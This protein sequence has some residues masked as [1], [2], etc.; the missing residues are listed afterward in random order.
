MFY[1]LQR[2]LLTLFL[3]LLLV[4]GFPEAPASYPWPQ[5]GSQLEHYLLVAQE[6]EKAKDYARSAEAYLN[7]LKIRPDWALIH[8]S[9]G[10]VYHLQSR[11]PEAI[12]V[13]EKALSLDPRLWGSR[14]FLGMDYYR[15]NQFSKAVP[16]LKKA[17]ELNPPLAEAEAR[18]W[19]GSSYLAMDRFEEAIEQWRRLIELRPGDLEVLYNLAQAYNRF[20]SSLFEAMGK[21]DLHSA[22]A[23]RLQAEWFESQ[24]RPGIA[25]EEYT[26]AAE[27]RPDWEGI[28]NAIGSIYARQGEIEKA[29]EAFENELKIVP[30]DEVVQKQLVALKE[31][32]NESH[33]VKKS[34]PGTTTLSQ[35]STPAFFSGAGSSRKTEMP[36]S[37]LGIEEFRARKFKEAIE[38][39]QRALDS[40]PNDRKA[41]LYLAR[42]YFASEQYDQAVQTLH[43][44]NKAAGQ[45]LEVLYWLGKSY[46]ELAASTLQ[47]MIDINPSSYRVHQISGKLF[48]EKTQFLKALESYQTALKLSPDLAGIRSDIGNVYRKMENLDEALI[49]LK[50]ELKINPYHALTNYRVGDIY[51]T[52]AS[53][54]LAVPYLEQAVQANPG[55]LEAQRE[56]GKALMDQRQYEKALVRLRIVA[57]AEPQDEGIHYLLAGAYRKLGN[58]EEAKV[59]LKRFNELNQERLERDRQRVSRKI[60]RDQS[61]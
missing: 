11:Y 22:E 13:F 14:L 37:S 47:K 26:K 25:V 33:P 51:M 61:Q 27:L 24:D 38:V 29:V 35:E 9:L 5:E 42:S 1:C 21:I 19:L 57:Q 44:L 2:A 58:L 40:N 8:Q 55:L 32:L 54:E 16:E 23:H 20:S 15:T 3:P 46:Q 45:D 49:W 17:I 28:H 39:L 10:V 52:K 7:I 56:L 50:E 41:S 18:H 48:E 34:E 12:A 43:R 36:L 4:L 53:P 60:L 31:K 30:N 59:E 6:A